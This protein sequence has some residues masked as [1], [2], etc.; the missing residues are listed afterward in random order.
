MVS[1]I[2]MKS[3]VKMVPSNCHDVSYEKKHLLIVF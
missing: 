1:V 3:L 2:I